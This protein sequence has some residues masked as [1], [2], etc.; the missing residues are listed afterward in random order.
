MR[1]RQS[2]NIRLLL[3]EPV[4]NRLRNVWKPLRKRFGRGCKPRPAAKPR[5]FAGAVTFGSRLENVSDGVANPVRLRNPVILP[6]PVCNRLRNVWK[7]LR[8]RFGRGSR[9]ELPRPAATPRRSGGSGYI[10]RR[11]SH[12]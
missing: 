7:P 1:Y 11:I 2:D 8:K 3:P 5:H 9:R 12:P 6:E 4:C 10:L